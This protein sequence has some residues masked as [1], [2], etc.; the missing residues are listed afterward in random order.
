MSDPAAARRGALRERLEWLTWVR[1]AFV[2]IWAA[3]PGW[4]VAW[5]ALLVI[6]GVLPAAVVALTKWLVD[7]IA[8]A[9]GAGTGGD[10][11]MAVLPPAA[12]MGAILLFQRIASGV[13]E[14]VSAGQS[15]HVG[16]Y[17]KGLLHEKAASVD[18][19][20]YE[21]SGYHDLLE[22]ANTQASGR[23]LQLLNNAG[24]LGRSGI[25]FFSIVV[26]LTT[27]GLWIPVVLL[28]GAAPA[29]LVVLRHNRIYHAWWKGAT[30]RRRMAQYFDL[31]LTMA[32]AA[33]EIRI[34]QIGDRFRHRYAD[35]R[36]DL[37]TESLTLLKRQ[38]LGRL[39]AATSALVVTAGVMGWIALRA[40]RG[41]AT[42]GDVAFFYGA[43]TQGQTLVGSLLQN[44]G[45]IYTN[46]L[47]MDHL[48]QF[49]GLTNKTQDPATPAPFPAALADGV[50]F[51]NVTFAYPEQ[52]RTAL[53]GFDLHVPAGKI[54]AIVGENG[55]GKSTF[56]K[57]LCRFYDPT[58]GRVTVDGTDLRDFSMADLRRRVAVLFQFPMQYQM[59]LAENVAVGNIDRE[60]IPANL[61]VAMAGAG[62]EALVKKLPAG[63]DTILGRWFATGTELSGGEWQR[64][65]LA[66][67]FFR[68]AP[69]VILDEPTSFMDSWAENEWLERF[70]RMVQGR[71]ALIITHRF[72]TAMQADIIHVMDAGRVV[73]S[74]T[75]QELVAFGGR[76]ASSWAAQ[77]RQAE[78]GGAAA[79]AAAA[80][81]VGE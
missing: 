37:R 60:P 21:S 68:E 81:P 51:E 15:E 4:T 38:V 24:V 36:R 29:F 49:L 80:L 18:F 71:T 41:Q 67:A 69:L 26:L 47:F 70:R 40:F 2:L 33:A 5:A 11:A 45:A 23:I 64:V 32:Q 73:E 31:M 48:I 43:F 22:Q 46:A 52:D 54:V 61:D 19:A 76:Y 42:L 65:A 75:H 58:S 57:L 20:F 13:S 72:T 30:P 55:A 78:S 28:V 12:L 17:V 79:V 1:S 10:A 59:S 25:T 35:M 7:S 44:V 27:Y 56:I 74:G 34:N 50:R 8:A 39:L 63:Y 66:R 9:V 14:W 16:D 77:M 3:A 53:D 62:A 6:Q